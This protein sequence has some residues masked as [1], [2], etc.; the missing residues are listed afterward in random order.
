MIQV[1]LTKQ[2]GIDSFF[3][4]PDS[5]GRRMIRV[6]GAFV[7]AWIGK[8]VTSLRIRLSKTPSKYDVC[9]I[10]F[11]GVESYSVCYYRTQNLVGGEWNKNHVTWI[12]G[13][14]LR[15]MGV[16]EGSYYLSATHIKKTKGNG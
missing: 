16:D 13:D 5:K 7:R 9:K 10:I 6:C 15:P 8:D 11:K 12:N 3:A 4:N 1:S 2:K 14:V